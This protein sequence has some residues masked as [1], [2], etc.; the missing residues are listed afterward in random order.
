MGYRIITEEL[1]REIMG[2]IESVPKR[3]PR[4]FVILH[5]ECDDLYIGRLLV[6]S[7]YGRSALRGYFRKSGIQG[8]H[9]ECSYFAEDTGNK[10]YI[11]FTLRDA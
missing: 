2:A 6:A 10:Q 3:N 5:G 1:M 8:L 11:E 7:A 9:F 4:K